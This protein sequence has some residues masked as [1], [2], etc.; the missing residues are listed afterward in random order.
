MFNE[1]NTNDCNLFILLAR[2]LLSAKDRLWLKTSHVQGL[3]NNAIVKLFTPL[4]IK[5]KSYLEKFLFNHQWE[6]IDF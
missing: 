1:W 5:F 2:D 6:S 3:E 4:F